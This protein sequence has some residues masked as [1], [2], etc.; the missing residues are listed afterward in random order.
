MIHV[1]DLHIKGVL[2]GYALDFVSYSRKKSWRLDT[3]L[4]EIE[5]KNGNEPET[6]GLNESASEF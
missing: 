4:I 3:Y 6:F 5:L 2:K 1:L